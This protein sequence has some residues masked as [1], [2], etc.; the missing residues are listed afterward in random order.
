[1]N[2]S[3]NLKAID[4]FC[5]AGGMSQGLQSAKVEDYGLQDARIKIIGALDNDIKCKDTYEANHPDSSLL[6]RDIKSYPEGDLEKDIPDLKKND[7]N[8]IFIGCSPCQHWSVIR[9]PRKKSMGTRNLLHDFLR[10]VEYYQPGFVVVEN[11]I[12]I[13]NNKKESGLSDLLDFL[14]DNDYVPKY[15]SLSCKQYGVPQTRRRFILIA[16]KNPKAKMKLAIPE[17]DD[18]VSVL[19]DALVDEKGHPLPKLQPGQ[20]SKADPLHRTAGLSEKNVSR[21]KLTVEGGDNRKWRTDDNL[22]IDTY[23][24]HDG[25]YSNYGRM[26][27]DKPAPTITTKFFSLGCGQFGHPTEDRTISLREGALLQTFPYSYKFKSTSMQD[28]ARLIGNAV[29]PAF[30]K[31]I[32]EAILRSIG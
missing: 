17:A 19:K 15:K 10:F 13:E 2:M 27:R 7:A 1:M 3:I 24:R 21:L 30:A 8:M 12:G 32:G 16:T 20:Y 9:H 22:G 26:H 25:F 6:L 29:P 23:R 14:I 4:F 18:K 28:T 11:V 5:G 31:R